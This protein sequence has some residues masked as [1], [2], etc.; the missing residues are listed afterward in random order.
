MS[1]GNSTCAKALT[2]HCRSWSKQLALDFFGGLSFMPYIMILNFLSVEFGRGTV[3]LFTRIDCDWL[4][5]VTGNLDHVE[6]LSRIGGYT[7][8]TVYILLELQKLQKYFPPFLLFYKWLTAL[9]EMHQVRGWVG[10]R[11]GMGAEQ[12]T[13]IKRKPAFW[14][15]C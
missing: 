8:L 14:A 13:Q 4:V 1:I 3:G 12:P 5:S 10:V 2:I 6:K 9:L 11:W 7:K 15:G